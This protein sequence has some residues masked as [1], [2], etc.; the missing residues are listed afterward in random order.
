MVP[1]PHL[2][3]PIHSEQ[4]IL[5]KIYMHRPVWR[6]SCSPLH[7]TVRRII[8]WSELVYSRKGEIWIKDLAVCAIGYYSTL[9]FLNYLLRW[10]LQ[11][12]TFCTDYKKGSREQ[13]CD[14]PLTTPPSVQENPGKR[15]QL[16]VE[17]THMIL[18]P[19]LARPIGRGERATFP[20][21]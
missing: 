17:C 8:V 1:H 12:R 10:Q 4:K 6:K 5:N 16:R 19:D 7:S 9:T 14:L 13:S 20:N 2:L 11:C 21:D 15:M 18:P 3:I